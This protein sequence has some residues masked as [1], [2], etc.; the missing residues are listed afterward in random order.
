M[1]AEE[2]LLLALDDERG[3]VHS[4]ASIGLDYGLAG[5]LLLELTLEGR[6][7]IEDNALVATGADSGDA[8]LDDTLALVRAKPGKK[9]A[10]WVTKL[11][12]RLKPLRGR[13]LQRLVA[14]GTLKKHERRILLIFHQTVHPE[15]D[16]R[17][18][19]DIRQ[20]LD[21][22]LLHGAEADT[23]TRALAQ[24][25]A[26]SRVSDALYGRAERKR[27]KQRLD[28]FERSPL[29]DGVTQAV[30]QAEQAAVMVAIMAASVAA[31]SAATSAACSAA[32]SSCST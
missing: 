19:H 12:G 20:R 24:L 30:M 22:V 4:S 21:A 13:L 15:R 31:T 26:A 11:P 9:V 8:L 28:E 10:Y 5:A 25:A 23:R 1:L 6:L 32:S 2:L 17:V 18:E 16:G 14:R 3:T 29:G 27:L 7:G